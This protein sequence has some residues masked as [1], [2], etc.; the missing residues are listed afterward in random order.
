MQNDESELE[1]IPIVTLPPPPDGGWG[2]V[3]VFAGFTINFL[4]NGSMLSL[5]VFL[6]TFVSHF[7]TS[8][9]SIAIANSIC[10][11]V[12]MCGMPINSALVNTFG[13]R[14]MC[15]LG[16]I[17]YGLGFFLT[18]LSTNIYIFC[19][20]YGVILGWSCG[21]I[22]LS[23]MGLVSFY[24]EKK[25]SL[26]N[27]I[28]MAGAPIGGAAWSPFGSYMLRLYGWKI[29]FCVF[30]GINLLICVLSFL[31]RPLA[32]VPQ[33]PDTTTTNLSEKEEIHSIYDKEN[34]TSGQ[35]NLNMSRSHIQCTKYRR[36]S[37]ISKS[38]LSLESTSNF[39]GN[40]IENNVKKSRHLFESELNGT[41]KKASNAVD[42]V[43]SPKIMDENTGPEEG[44]PKYKNGVLNI[45]CLQTSPLITSKTEKDKERKRS[46]IV[47][48]VDEKTST[49]LQPE[50]NIFSRRESSCIVRP[51]SRIDTFYDRSLSRLEINESKGR[52]ESQTQRY[53][54]ENEADEQLYTRYRH[55]IVSIQSCTN[56]DKN[57]KQISLN[58][59]PRGSV[60]AQH[61]R[62]K[63]N[64]I[65]DPEMRKEFDSQTV[66]LFK[67]ISNMLDI[68]YLKRPLFLL[69]SLARFFG[70]FSFFIPWT[71]LPSMMEKKQIDPT[72][73]SFLLTFLGITCLVSRILS[74]V[75]LDRP[76]IPSP[77]VSTVSTMVAGVAM[78]LLPFCYNFETFAIVGCLYGLFSGG[79]VT[80]QTIVLVDM[81]G[82]ESLVSALGTDFLTYIFQYTLCQIK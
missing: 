43:V 78:L 30:G 16:G 71:F 65:Q 80:S 53:N 21:L 49:S 10:L 8:H 32:L 55:S 41:I 46:V 68:S 64:S 44:H 51:F 69:V 35:D 81:F 47:F 26:S 74:G 76:K 5:G 79:Y 34:K 9:Q 63:K 11:G 62:L 40:G 33:S 66:S 28:C 18:T 6:E 60:L 25:R 38:V 29:T 17:V 58:M 70:D 27:A 19:F 77:V 7:E 24:F 72:K 54:N 20:T 12:L 37:I 56:E 22:L 67:S 4:N 39:K 13:C 23:W 73:A 45:I 31:L 42:S 48:G 2:W 59:L 52:N 15:F 14:K 75:L 57:E 61:I 3:I 82:M 1:T 36:D 50:K